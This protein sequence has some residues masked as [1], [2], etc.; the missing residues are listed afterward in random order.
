MSGL[1]KGV[2]AVFS[3]SPEEEGQILA[4]NAMISLISFYEIMLS[5]IYT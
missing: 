1:G 2:T 4:R 3:L 5:F